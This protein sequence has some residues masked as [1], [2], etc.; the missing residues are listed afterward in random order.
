MNTER[1]EVRVA[2]IEFMLHNGFTRT[3]DDKSYNEQI[4]SIEE[5][6]QL[7]ADQVKLMFRDERLKKLRTKKV[8]VAQFV[9]SEGERTIDTLPTMQNT[10]VSMNT[11]TTTTEDEFVS[12][13][14]VFEVTEA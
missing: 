1:K 14:E 11:A 12:S 3:K 8:A 6:Y 10:T 2:D 4:G 9:I 13:G 5:H 7:S